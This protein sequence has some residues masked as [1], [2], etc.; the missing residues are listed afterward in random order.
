MTKAEIERKAKCSVLIEISNV[1]SQD[2]EFEGHMIQR[3]QDRAYKG[4]NNTKVD[5]RRV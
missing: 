4:V 2:D 5:C 1:T 3:I